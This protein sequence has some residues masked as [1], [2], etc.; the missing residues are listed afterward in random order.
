MLP[1][2]LL[3]NRPRLKLRR[4]KRRLPLRLPRRLK[5]RP[6][7]SRLLKQSLPKLPSLLPK[8][9]P[10]LKPRRLKLSRLPLLRLLH[11]LL[12]L[13]LRPPHS[14]RFA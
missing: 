13:P 8:Q 9:S 7:P 5:R 11:P 4:L 14:N 1:L 12:L 6:K 10:L 2:T 3:L